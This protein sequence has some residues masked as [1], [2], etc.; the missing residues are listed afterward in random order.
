MAEIHIPFHDDMQQAI[1]DGNK[2]MTS[3]F[4]KY[5]KTGDTFLVRGHKYE[6]TGVYRQDLGKVA[7]EDYRL[8]GFDSPLAF[9][10]KWEQIHPKRCRMSDV[11]WSHE[12]KAVA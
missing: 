3:R 8:E 12:F 4:R 5:G 6:I 7:K 1:V 11:V 10:T 2:T 9:V